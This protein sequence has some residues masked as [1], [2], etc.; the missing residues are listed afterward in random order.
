[1]LSSQKSD[2]S[3]TIKSDKK[4]ISRAQR[5]NSR[6]NSKQ[7]NNVSVTLNKND[8]SLFDA[9]YTGDDLSEINPQVIIPLTS[10]LQTIEHAQQEPA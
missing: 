1:M 9:T 5:S 2:P 3:A 7:I 4:R 8:V 6:S 10:G